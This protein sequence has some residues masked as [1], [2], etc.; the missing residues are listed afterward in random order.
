VGDGWD[1]ATFAEAVA[2]TLSRP[3]GVAARLFSIRAEACCPGPDPDAA[4]AAL[5]PADRRRTGR[6]AA[7]LARANVAIIGAPQAVGGLCRG[8]WRQG[9]APDTADGAAMTRAGLAAATAAPRWSHRMSR[10]L[11]AILRGIAPDEATRRRRTL[12]DAGIDRIEVP[13]NSPD[14]FDSIA[15]WRAP[16]ARPR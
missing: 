15:R 3:E 1:D 6:R 13:L 2:D 12:I 5:G 14:P 10:P 11:I 16:M 9:V 7:L 8:A 4:N